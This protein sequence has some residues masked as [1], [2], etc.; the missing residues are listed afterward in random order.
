M[1]ES[2]LAQ[3]PNDIDALKGI[4]FA[5]DNALVERDKKI[6]ILEE[7][8]RFL[9]FK[10][11]GKSSER[12]TSDLQESLF[13]EAEQLDQEAPAEVDQPVADNTASGPS[14]DNA[15]SAEPKRPGRRKL[16]AHLP[17][18]KVFHELPEADRQCPCGCQLEAFDEVISEQLGIIP[19]DLYVIQHCRKK[20][21]CSQCV[22]QAPITHHYRP[23]LSQ[24]ATPAPS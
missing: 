13:N 19:A 20:Y 16:P 22:E 11:F 21:R 12:F 24:K 9:K 7:Y 3:L 15:A 1:A 4:I 2:S 5:R 6:A 17:R 10:Q 8:V 18:I 23:S 14:E